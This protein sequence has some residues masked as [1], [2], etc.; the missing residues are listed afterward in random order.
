MYALI[1][2]YAFLSA[3][4]GTQLLDAVGV[5]IDVRHYKRLLLRSKKKRISHRR[6]FR[7]FSHEIRLGDIMAIMQVRA[8]DPTNESRRI[9]N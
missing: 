5:S 6:V 1:Y 8:F 7:V 4:V 3:C 9:Y 2:T